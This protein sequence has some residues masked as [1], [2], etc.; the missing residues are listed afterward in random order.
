MIQTLLWILYGIVTLW[1]IFSIVLHGSR[2]TKSLSWFLAVIVLPFAGPI[3]YYLFGVNRRKFKFFRLKQ[4][5]KRKLFNNKY[6]DIHD[7]E[8][9]VTFNSTKE[10]KLAELI[11]NSALLSPYNGNN[12]TILNGG[13][14][15]F[16]SIFEELEKAK[17][18]IHLQYYIFSEG[19]LTARFYEI[20]K[21]KIAQGVEVRLIYDSFGSSSFQGNTIKRFKAIGVKAFPMMPIRFGS[22]LFT[23]N[24]RN[25]RKIIIIDGTIGFTGGV[26]VSDKYIKPISDLG[27]WNDIHLKIEGPAVNSLHRVF[28]KD[29]YFASNEKLLLNE[30]YLPKTI[31][32]GHHTVQVVAAG[33]DSKHPAIMQ[34]YISMITL[35]EK[36][37]CI[38]NP[39]FIPSTAVI[40]ALKIAALSGVEVHIL[41]PKKSDS[42]MAKLSMFS[43]FESLLEVGIKIYLRSDFSHSKMILIDD[44]IASVGSGNFDYRSFEHNFETNVLLYD[45]EL[46]KQ[47]K[48]EFDEISN[49]YI[50]LDYKSYK[51]RPVW[52]KLLEGFAKF[53]SPLL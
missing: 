18:F 40:Q 6:K 34:Q 50:P 19:E 12:V 13:E 45:N 42:K 22:L 46:T 47:I 26:N 36:C 5:E 35:A 9:K 48:K 3:L 33:P 14:Q 21:N 17:K 51:N 41:V 31:S 28:I 11:K 10:K 30:K 20:L 37:I 32:K 39:Y 7:L 43:R 1:S 24:Y 15:T 44:E 49:Q 38:A 8:N 23:L 52:K 2:P 4:T 27:I 53:F 25:H 16:D 29:Y